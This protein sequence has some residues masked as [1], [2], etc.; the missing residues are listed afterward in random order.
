MEET[1]GQDGEFNLVYLFSFQLSTGL[2]FCLVLGSVSDPFC[3]VF[4]LLPLLPM[5]SRCFHSSPFVWHRFSAWAPSKV[6]D[7]LQLQHRV[8]IPGTWLPASL[9]VSALCKWMCVLPA[10]RK[11]VSGHY[12]M[13]SPFSTFSGHW[14]LFT[15][16][17]LLLVSW[18]LQETTLDDLHT[19]RELCLTW[20]P[21]SQHRENRQRYEKVVMNKPSLCRGK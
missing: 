18:Y 2:V 19:A 16:S 11:E 15:S 12:L 10:H 17:S 4:V 13:D 9:T 1:G 21:Y 6:L 7:S 20:R 8:S 14:Q 3:P 5:V